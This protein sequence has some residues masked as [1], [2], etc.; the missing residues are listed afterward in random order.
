MEMVGVCDTRTSWRRTWEDRGLYLPAKLLRREGKGTSLPSCPGFSFV[1]A[2]HQQRIGLL[3]PRHVLVPSILTYCGFTVSEA[4]SLLSA[5]SDHPKLWDGHVKKWEP[6]K[7]FQTTNVSYSTKSFSNKMMA[8]L[9]MTTFSF[10]KNVLGCSGGVCV[11]MN[12]FK[13]FRSGAHIAWSVQDNLLGC[14]QKYLLFC[15]PFNIICVYDLGSLRSSWCYQASSYLIHE[16]AL[17]PTQD[18]RGLWS[19]LEEGWDFYNRGA[20]GGTHAQMSLP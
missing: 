13:G 4:G 5:Y 16:L 15:L 2:G 11:S 1:I 9:A 12:Y 20:H 8:W 18:S 3:P 17:A 19:V 14:R 7:I 6:C 10:F